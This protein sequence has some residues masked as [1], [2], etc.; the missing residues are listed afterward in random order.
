MQ[1]KKNDQVIVTSG[2]SKNEK[3]RV[4]EILV[5]KGQVIIH[6]VN[7]RHK[8]VKPS[9]ENP[10]GGRIEV[11]APIALSSVMAYSEKADAPSRIKIEKTEDGK[12]V[13][14]LKKCGSEY[15]EKY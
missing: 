6:G 12:K 3:G 8:H 7:K 14:V 9:Q 2:N 5:S 11:E 10:Q 1:I 4:K 15:G 13:R